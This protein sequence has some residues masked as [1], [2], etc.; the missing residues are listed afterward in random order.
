MAGP[1]T[2]AAGD[3]SL[4]EVNHVPPSVT[5]GA[6]S[7]IFDGGSSTPVT[8]DSTLTVSDQDSGGNLASAT[9]S[10]ASGFINGDTLELH[11]PERHHRQLRRRARHADADRHGQRRRLSDGAG[12]HHLQLQPVERRSDQRRRR[13]QPATISWVVD[14]GNTISGQDS[15]TSTLDIVHVA[16][17]V[18]AGG[19]VTFT[20]GGVAGD[21]R[22]R[23]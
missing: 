4:V 13:H 19:T 6:Q 8:L 11:Q 21:A 20:G 3:T 17:T 2:A 22:Q 14:D 10:I 12:V 7:V 23:A 15:D 9:V 16:P 5:A 1:A 18:T